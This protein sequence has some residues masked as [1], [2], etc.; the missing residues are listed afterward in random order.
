MAALAVA[1][2]NQY[3]TWNQISQNVPNY[4][5]A[6]FNDSYAAVIPDG[7]LASGGN[8]G[9]SG[10]DFSGLDLASD[11]WHWPATPVAAGPLE[12]NWFATATHDPLLF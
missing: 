3:Y 12:I 6:A 4:A 9:K 7:Q 8:I 2:S 11:A 10:L 5:A 1:G